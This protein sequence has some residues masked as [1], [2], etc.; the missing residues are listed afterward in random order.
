MSDRAAI[1]RKVEEYFENLWRSGD[2]WGFGSS[3]YERLKYVRQMQLLSDR[4]YGR[5]LEIGCAA[6]V[7]TRMLAGIADTVVGI[8]IAAGAI[9]L[10]S[11]GDIPP[12]V[13]FRVANAM[14][15]DVVAEGPWDLIV[16][17]ETIY[18][19]GWLYP[20]FDV[21]WMAS[22]LHESMAAG[23]R[24]LMADLSGGLEE[25]LNRPWI[26]RT[27]R[28]LMVNVGFQR[29]FEELYRGTKDSVELETT[30][31]RFVRGV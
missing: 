17:S 4:R 23:G 14:E 22:Q 10:A 18:Y 20:L 24:L 21:A 29:E 15:F 6:G 31:T 2:P 11:A 13:E 28:D 3:E 1:H 26:I 27:Y 12:G 30:I 9:T 25:Y 19:L 7:F 8:D 5:V 16:M